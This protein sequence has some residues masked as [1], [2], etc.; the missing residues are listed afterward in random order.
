M[1]LDG[2]LY[3]VIVTWNISA[4]RF[5]INIYDQQ[6]NWIITTALVSTP[7]GRTVKSVDYDPFL[8]ILNVEMV[9]PSLWPIPVSPEGILTKPGQIVEYTL[10][11]FTPDTYNGTY[12]AMT[13]SPTKFSF[14]MASDPGPVNILGTVNR[15]LNMAAPV[16]RNSTLV[17]RNGAF[18]VNP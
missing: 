4:L 13:L 16:F 8:S 1:T 6:G 10:A 12:R 14:A 18:E 11:G 2:N 3:S 9:D 7:P 5:Y 17:Y 15:L